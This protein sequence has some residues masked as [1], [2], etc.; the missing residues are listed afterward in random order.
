MSTRALFEGLVS[1]PDGRAVNV[2]LVGGAAQYVVEDNGFK[3]HIDA[4]GVDRQVLRHLGGQITENRDAVSE[5]V[6]KMMGQE[7]LFTKAAIDSSLKN[8]DAQFDHLIAQGLPEQARAFM[9]MMGF[10]IV[11]NYHGEVERVE[12]PSAPE[13]GDGGE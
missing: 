5:G 3:F 10:R 9:G 13:S 4:E 11:L 6:M 1:D 7:D 2:T 12:Q 8:L